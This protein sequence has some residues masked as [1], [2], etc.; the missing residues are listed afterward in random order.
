VP[1]KIARSPWKNPPI[2]FG[3]ICVAASI[4]VLFWRPFAAFSDVVAASVFFFILALLSLID[5]DLRRYRCWYCQKTIY[6]FRR[7]I[8]VSWHE[9]T[10]YFYKM[11]TLSVVMHRRCHEA[12]GENQFRVPVPEYSSFPI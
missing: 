5:F 11:V 4:A 7:S 3:M 1:E 10:E 12:A 6:P 9:R 8:E 2:V